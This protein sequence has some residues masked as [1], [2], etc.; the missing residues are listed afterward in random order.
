MLLAHLGSHHAVWRPVAGARVC[1]G[2]GRG[3]C[4]FAPAP[5]STSSKTRR[6]APSGPCSIGYSEPPIG[7]QARTQAKQIVPKKPPPVNV[8]VTLARAAGRRRIWVT[9][10]KVWGCSNAIPKAGGAEGHAMQHGTAASTHQSGT[11]SRKHPGRVLAGHPSVW[12]QTA[13]RSPA[14]AR[15][16]RSRHTRTCGGVCVARA[17]EC[18]AVSKRTPRAHAPSPHDNESGAAPTPLSAPKPTQCRQQQAAH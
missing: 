10:Q 17:H 7:L 3:G 18:I 13:R 5:G 16:P 15:A 12:H 8:G 14:S 2:G 1:P 6:R 9:R 4:G 11:P